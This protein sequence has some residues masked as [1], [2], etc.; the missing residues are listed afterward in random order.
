VVRPAA[1]RYHEALAVG[2]GINVRVIRAEVFV[3]DEALSLGQV[4][5]PVEEGS[6]QVGA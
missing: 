2:P 6:G 1:I 5:D 3:G 4:Q